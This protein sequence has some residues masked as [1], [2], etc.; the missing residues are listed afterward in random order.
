MPVLPTRSPTTSR[1]NWL[2]AISIWALRCTASAVRST[3]AM[4]ARLPSSSATSPRTTS[5][6]A[7]AG[8][9][10]MLRRR[11]HWSPRADRL[12]LS[13]HLPTARD[14]RAV[15]FL[16]RAA[17]FRRKTLQAGARDNDWLRLTGDDQHTSRAF[18]GSVAM[19][20]F[21][22]AAMMFGTA[23]GAQAADMPDFLHGSLL[24]SGPSPTATGR[25]F[26]SAA[27]GR[28]GE[29]DMNFTGR[30]K[31]SSANNLLRDTTLRG[32]AVPVSTWPLEQGSTRRHRLRRV[33]SVTTSQWDN[34]VLGVEAQLSCT[35]QFGGIATDSKSGPIQS[36]SR[37]WLCQPVP[38][39]RTV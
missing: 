19:R 27:R 37:P 13:R 26:T 1:S 35:G 29:S 15:L 31:A 21:L 18:D 9:A 14:S 30:R 36:L 4:P 24:P 12:S 5:G 10:A 34:V 16:R 39:P 32:P 2:T 6:L 3:A 22:L 7:C 20:R 25:A 23:A 28:V 11:R 8:P 17:G 38:L 33:S